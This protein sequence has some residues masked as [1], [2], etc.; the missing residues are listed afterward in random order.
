LVAALVS[1]IEVLSNPAG[2]SPS[3]RLLQGVLPQ[4]HWI[5]RERIIA[6]FPQQFNGFVAPS[7]LGLDE[8]RYF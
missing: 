8:K 1:Y 6:S 3:C 2:A 7:R 4:L 5:T